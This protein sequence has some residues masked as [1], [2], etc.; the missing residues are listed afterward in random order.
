M[1]LYFDFKIQNDDEKRKRF[2]EIKFSLFLVSRFILKP[3]FCFASSNAIRI[4]SLK[5]LKRPIYNVNNN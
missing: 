4:F 5:R 2:G 3:V 1:D